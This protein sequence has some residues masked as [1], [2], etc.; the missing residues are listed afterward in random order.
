M[1]DSKVFA[2]TH[3]I[4]ELRI[5]GLNINMTQR[6][7][8]SQAVFQ[9]CFDLSE[10]PPLA[11]REIFGRKWKDLNPNREA[12]IDG[13][14]LVM[15]SPLQEV[16]ATQLPALKAAIKATNFA[17]RQYVRGQLTEEE[18]RTDVLMEEREAVEHLAKSLLFD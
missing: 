2:S 12:K 17:Y 15:H 3:S 9:V 14:F 16:A 13:K 8:G 4:T 18:R 6:T 11:W 1:I 10:T 7:P 5:L